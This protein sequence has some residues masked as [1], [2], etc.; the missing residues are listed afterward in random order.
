MKSPSNYEFVKTEKD[1]EDFKALL[2]VGFGIN[3]YVD[4]VV[5][6]RDQC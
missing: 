3:V 5:K 2:N 6:V 4:G 1:N